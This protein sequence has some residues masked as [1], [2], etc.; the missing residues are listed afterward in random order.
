MSLKEVLAA[1][2]ALHAQLM[3]DA[4]G[5]VPEEPA[6]P[7]AVNLG[8]YLSG[9]FPRGAVVRLMVLK[10][11]EPRLRNAAAAEGAEASATSSDSAAPVLSAPGP[12]Q[13]SSDAA[14]PES[15]V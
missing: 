5:H 1:Y 3:I 14:V 7:Y 13:P 12:N 10:V 8:E 4:G 2:P 11:I 9:D 15:N 6:A